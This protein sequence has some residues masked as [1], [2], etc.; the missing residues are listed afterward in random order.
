MTP[1]EL[2][3]GATDVNAPERRLTTLYHHIY[4]GWENNRMLHSTRN[5]TDRRII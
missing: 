1:E 3:G 5:T 2:R 4:S